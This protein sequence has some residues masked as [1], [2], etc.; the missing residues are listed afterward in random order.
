ML[1]GMAG[2]WQC[3]TRMEILLIQTFNLISAAIRVEVRTRK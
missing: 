3:S 1:A 2:L